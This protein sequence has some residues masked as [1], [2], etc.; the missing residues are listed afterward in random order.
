MDN[1]FEYSYSAESHREVEEIRR[2]YVTDEND[3]Y[4][5]KLRQL[6]DL[7]RSA[8]RKGMIVS[9][10]VGTVST[11]LLGL[12]MSCIMVWNDPLFILGVVLGVL[13]LIGVCASYPLFQRITKRERKRIAP[14]ILKLSEELEKMSS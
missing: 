11:M 13:G 12:G 7:D 9:I 8:S 3:S 14:M 1:N 5:S 6:K 2:K 10:A 4:E